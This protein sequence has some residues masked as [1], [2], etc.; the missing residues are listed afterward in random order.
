MFIK[1]GSTGLENIKKL[2]V[3]SIAAIMRMDWLCNLIIGIDD[4]NITM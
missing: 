1:D 2:K 3:V 4:P